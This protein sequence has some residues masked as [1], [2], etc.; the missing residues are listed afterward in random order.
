MQRFDAISLRLGISGVRIRRNILRTF[1]IQ[2]LETFFFKI[3]VTFLRF[4]RFK[5]FI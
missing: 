2:R 1:F 5:F 4:Q 3:I